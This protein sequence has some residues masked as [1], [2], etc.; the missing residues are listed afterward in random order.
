MTGIESKIITTF[1]SVSPFSRSILSAAA[2]PPSS[3]F[4]VAPFSRSLTRASASS[5]SPGGGE[6]TLSGPSSPIFVF[7]HYADTISHL[8]MSHKVGL[9]V[10]S[11]TLTLFR[12]N[13]LIR[14]GISCGFLLLALPRA[15]VDFPR[16]HTTCLGALPPVSV[17]SRS[18]T[19]EEFVHIWRRAISTR[20]NVQSVGRGGGG[21]F[22][23]CLPA[24]LYI[25]FLTAKNCR[26]VPR[27]RPG[28]GGDETT[29]ATVGEVT[30]PSRPS[31]DRTS[32]AGLRISSSSSFWRSR[33][34]GRS[35]RVGPIRRLKSKAR[36]NR[37]FHVKSNFGA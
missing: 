36:M 12:S 16:N 37:E 19:E 8:E 25:D 13:V 33:T 22:P 1:L 28:C 3:D 24:V 20:K 29:A 15:A 14:T 2:I 27:W 5:S 10:L 9:F 34:R 31:V 11:F 30:S 17:V 6:G 23:F 18:L 26:S 7:C 32:W 4:F 21:G 35:G